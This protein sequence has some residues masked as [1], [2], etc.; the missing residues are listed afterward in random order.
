LPRAA[1]DQKCRLHLS[2]VP[3]Q[4][5]QRGGVCVL[6]RRDVLVEHSP[7]A[8]RRGLGDVVGR[9]RQLAQPA[10]GVLQGA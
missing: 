2:V 5:L 7:G 8:R 10:P 6:E 1:A 9:Q 3:E 4:P